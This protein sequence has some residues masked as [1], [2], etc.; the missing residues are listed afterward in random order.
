MGE[1]AKN[2]V[3]AP[4]NPVSFSAAI[5]VSVAGVPKTVG[6]CNRTDAVWAALSRPSPLVYNKGP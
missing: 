4:W 6:R 1:R 2:R 3:V 5:A